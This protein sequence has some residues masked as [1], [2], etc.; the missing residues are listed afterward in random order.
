MITDNKIYLI[1]ESLELSGKLKRLS[2]LV[3]NESKKV[4][5]E[6]IQGIEQNQFLILSL[7]SEKDYLSVNQIS[8]YLKITHPAAVQLL[9]KLIKKN[10]VIKYDSPD[11]KRITL[12]KLTDEGKSVFEQLKNS[13]EKIEISLKEIID[14]VDPK[15]LITLNTIEEKLKTKG[16]FERVK[17]KIKEEQLKSIKIVKHDDRYN[18]IFKELNLVWLN[19]F[20]EVEDEDKKALEDPN[21]YYLKNGGEIFFALIDNKVVGTCAIKRIDKKTF[22][23]SKM[24]VN[25]EHQGKQIGKKLAFTAIG[26]AVEENAEKI[27]LETSP[28][29][30]AAINLYKKLG[31]QIVDEPLKTKYKRALIKMELN[32]K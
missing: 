21:E 6:I 15:F 30:V 1:F 3:V 23:L 16:I 17:E 14:E 26:Y 31:F 22:E 25:E 13:A 4:L 28:R 9:N 7:L 12:V 11:D 20:F 32:L 27:I 24:A 18:R 10:Y 2:Q 19:K 8:S 29:L 5:F